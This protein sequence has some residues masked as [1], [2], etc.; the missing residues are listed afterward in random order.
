MPCAVRRDNALSTVCLF[1]GYTPLRAHS[2]SLDCTAGRD[3]GVDKLQ[4]PGPVPTRA[5]AG[6]NSQGIAVCNKAESCWSTRRMIQSPGPL[7]QDNV[8]AAKRLKPSSWACSVRRHNARPV[9]R[10]ATTVGHSEPVSAIVLAPHWVI[11]RVFNMESIM[12]LCTGLCGLCC[13]KPKPDDH[14][15][16]RQWWIEWEVDGASGST[17]FDGTATEA[18]TEWDTKFKPAGYKLVRIITR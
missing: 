5:V 9:I 14:G 4:E 13:N 10:N 1:N 11:R 6:L 18:Q 8:N 12:H 17:A 2:S 15:A 7:C 16:R 3:N